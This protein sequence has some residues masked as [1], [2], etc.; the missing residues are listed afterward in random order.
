[1]PIMTHKPLH[2]LG[3]RKLRP[4]RLRDC[5]GATILE[6]AIVAP[7]LLFLFMGMI[8]LGMIF[9]TQSVIESATNIGARVGKTGY[10]D[11]GPLTR[12]EFIKQRIV[13]LSGGFLDI[14]KIDIVMYAYSDFDNIEKCN[15]PPACTSFDDVNGNTTFDGTEG[16]GGPGQVVVYAVSYPWPIFTPGLR[17]LVFGRQPTFTISSVATVRNEMFP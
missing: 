11:P 9:F 1:M 2:K 6:F 16:P 4:S 13:Q 8:E 7:V 17:E 14:N 3:L 5:E 10:D 15:N 12:K